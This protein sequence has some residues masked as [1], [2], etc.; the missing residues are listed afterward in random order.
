MTL[1][2][3]LLRVSYENYF[4]KNVCSQDCLDI[5]L[6]S[7]VLLFLMQLSQGDMRWQEFYVQ[8]PAGIIPFMC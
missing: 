6:V 7:C 4:W 3:F 1:A 5:G 2:D 8:A